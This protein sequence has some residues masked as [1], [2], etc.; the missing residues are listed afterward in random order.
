MSDTGVYDAIQ[1]KSLRIVD[2]NGK[3]R[4]MLATLP[5]GRAGILLIDQNDRQRGT[6]EML[7][8][9][10][11]RLALLDSSGKPKLQVMLDNDDTASIRTCDSI[12]AMTVE[13]RRMVVLDSDETPRIM[14]TTEETGTAGV[15]V[16][17][18][19]MKIRA[20]MAVLGDGTAKV[21]LSNAEGESRVQLYVNS[22]EEQH[23]GLMIYYRNSATWFILAGDGKQNGVMGTVDPSGNISW[24]GF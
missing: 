11:T 7:P 16:G 23:A 6:F 24:R 9:G 13:A 8:D 12:E 3:T 22:D 18:A 19:A 1:T 5:T 21:L 20:Q 17:D 10:E 4:L 2:A 15:A 14:M